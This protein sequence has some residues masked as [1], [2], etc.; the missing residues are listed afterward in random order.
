MNHRQRRKANP[1]CDF[2]HPMPLIVQPCSM[3]LSLQGNHNRRWRGHG[4]Q[5]ERRI[6]AESNKT[7]AN[8][9]LYLQSLWTLPFLG[10]TRPTAQTFLFWELILD[11]GFI[12][13]CGAF[14]LG[15]VPPSSSSHLYAYERQRLVF[16]LFDREAT[17]DSELLC[18]LPKITQLITRKMKIK[19]RFP[20]CQTRILSNHPCSFLKTIWLHI[21]LLC[22][23]PIEKKIYISH[24]KTCI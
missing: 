10:K 22:I 19:H 4:R 13:L 2:L 11:N 21:P 15:N 17:G 12:V 5:K 14:K 1:N 16:I 20:D 6:A 23:Y 3:G 24:T 7:T 18:A 8:A 9:I